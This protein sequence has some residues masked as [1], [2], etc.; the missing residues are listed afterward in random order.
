MVQTREKNKSAHPGQPMAPRPRKSKEQAAAERAA[1]VAASQ[2]KVNQRADQ[3]A[4]LASLEQRMAGESQQVMAQ[5]AR[6]PTLQI[7]K[8]ASNVSANAEF[9][10]QDNAG[11]PGKRCQMLNQTS[12][13]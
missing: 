5:A 7:Q 6:P 10:M 2:K 13:Y 9:S 8:L 12:R 1:K 3:I 4:G 11:L